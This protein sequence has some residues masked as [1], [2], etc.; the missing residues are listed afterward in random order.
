MAHQT[1]AG[2]Q[3]AFWDR[4]AL[5]YAA[6]PI[7]DI[8]SYERKLALT[9][10]HLSNDSRVLEFGCGTGGTALRHA[11]HVEHVLATDYSARMIAIAQATQSAQQVE[12]VEFRQASLNQIGPGDGPFDAILGLNVL[13][14][15]PDY[16]E[17]IAYCHGLLRP[18]GLLVTSTVCLGRRSPLRFV[19]PI[20][21]VAGLVPK[22]V[23]LDADQLESDMR[24]AGFETIERED[25]GRSLFLIGRKS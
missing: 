7:A 13:H 2:T 20:P 5:R 8:P 16:R 18:G 15:I 21:A 17:C 3:P 10:R 11:E 4:H 25:F 23:Y 24:S 6:K 9:Q 1:T 19:L 12:N 14:L 22:L